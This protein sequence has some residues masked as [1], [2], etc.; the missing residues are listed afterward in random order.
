[1]V[2]MILHRAYTV[3]AVEAQTVAMY[4]AVVLVLAAV[5]FVA[6]RAQV[7]RTAAVRTDFPTG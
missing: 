2:Y 1:M 7:A 4:T 6:A 3:V 5:V